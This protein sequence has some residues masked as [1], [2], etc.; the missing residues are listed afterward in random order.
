[1][2]D[3]LNNKNNKSANKTIAD[4]YGDAEIRIKPIEDKALNKKHSLLNNA[5]IILSLIS[6]YLMALL[7]A[8]DL[9]VYEVYKIPVNYSDIDI[10]R[11]LPLLV[12]GIGIYVCIGYYAGSI[13]YDYIIK[14]NTFKFS[15]LLWGCVVLLTILSRY[16]NNEKLL[17]LLSLL[18]PILFELMFFLYLL[19]NKRDTKKETL[20]SQKYEMKVN[21]II[22]DHFVF[23]HMK[24]PIVAFCILLMIF[25]PFWSSFLSRQKTIYETLKINNCNYVI[26]SKAGENA[27]IETYDVCG[28]SAIIHT[29]EY[30]K[31]SISEH[32]IRLVKFD[33]VEI[34]SNIAH[35]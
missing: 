10:R 27:Y 2:T 33:K 18:F 14:K 28:D 22:A 15:R 8:Y 17:I 11:F 29:D 4:A 12:S 24:K 25:A 1:M 35:S 13:K 6:I 21:E 20:S 7:Y 3:N 34:E 26:V 30:M 5:A 32:K 9:G 23:F 31:I 19:I 16:L